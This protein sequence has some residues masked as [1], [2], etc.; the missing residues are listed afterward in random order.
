MQSSGGPRTTAPG[1]LSQL[2][3]DAVT[4]HDKPDALQYKVDG[5]YQ[6]ISSR[7]LAERVRRA[8]LG[9]SELGVKAG[10][11]VAIFSENRPE[12]AL[13][14]YA[15]VTS[16]LTDVPLY[17]NLPPEQAAYIIRDSGAV[18]IFVSDASLNGSFAISRSSRETLG[19]IRRFTV[20][21]RGA[22]PR[23]MVRV[24][25]SEPLRRSPGPVADSSCRCDGPV[26]ERG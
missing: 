25:M 5:V 22:I 6:P 21:R 17:P 1:T 2:F 24:V 12:W 7:L 9:L 10:D 18:A 19:C 26:R 16:A 8:A 20:A 11:R 23:F 13:A 3:F 15:C 14:D 4:R